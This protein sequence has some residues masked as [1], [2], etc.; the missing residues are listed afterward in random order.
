MLKFEAKKNGT[1]LPEI[2]TT[3]SFRRYTDMA[4]FADQHQLPDGK[5]YIFN[6]TGGN[7]FTRYRELTRDGS[8]FHVEGRGNV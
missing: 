1:P 4:N 7:L 3:K 2:F 5:Y 6:S 8:R